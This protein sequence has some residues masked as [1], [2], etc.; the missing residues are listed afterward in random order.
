MSIVVVV[1]LAALSGCVQRDQLPFPQFAP[2]LD[3]SP[4]ADD[5]NSGAFQIYARSATDLDQAPG[6]KRSVLLR[7]SYS[8]SQREALKTVAKPLIER[9]REAL[10]KPCHIPYEPPDS[11]TSLQ[12]R[13]EWR[14]L[15]RIL[16]WQIEDE[17]QN[18]KLDE[19][20]DHE[21]LLTKFGF[22]LT[23]GPPR[24]ASLGFVLVDSGRKAIVASLVKLD[25]AQL[26]RLAE[27]VKSV[28]LGRPKISA[29]AE[30]AAT[31]MLEQVQH[32]QD[33]YR[34]QNYGWIQ[35]SLGEA[36]K[37]PIEY[38]K[39]L[40]QEPDRKR[41]EFFAGFA[42]EAKQAGSLLK[43][44]A[45]LPLRNRKV[46]ETSVPSGPR[47]WKR[48]ARAFFGIGKPVLQMNDA[49]C[50][51]TQLLILE[52]EILAKLKTDGQTPADLSGFTSALTIDPFSGEPFVYRTDGK[53]HRLYS[54][55]ADLVDDN[56]ET[57]ESF[58][59]PDLALERTN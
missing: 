56:G 28:Y 14:L 52:S 10:G 31:D 20:I 44:E 57:D 32:V 17:C 48:L 38:L 19:A 33:C 35:N 55:G 16:S 25:A 43:Q 12:Y 15:G 27:G 59:K 42:G 2:S 54:V 53:D 22:D 45:G 4:G 40:Q 1:G 8:P 13:P 47:P 7:T 5:P 39:D 6:F 29:C 23:G 50:A 9:L 11:P 18:E 3:R 49:T 37:E 58:T 51:R 21:I 24:D 36:S 26:R 34:D 46:L 30:A 41:V